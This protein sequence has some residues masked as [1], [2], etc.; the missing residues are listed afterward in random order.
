M[1][2]PGPRP[3]H[4]NPNPAISILLS[5]IVETSVGGMPGKVRR[6]HAGDVSLSLD[7][8][9]Q[10]HLTNV[11][12]PEPAFALTLLM[13]PAQVQALSQRVV[14]WPIDIVMPERW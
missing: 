13:T 6:S 12:G 5:G 3:W 10:G 2:Q 4:P 8:L 7:A 9:G 14:G 11:I 1:L